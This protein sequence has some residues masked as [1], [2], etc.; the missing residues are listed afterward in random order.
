MSFLIES[1]DKYDVR[2]S[3]VGFADS[4]LNRFFSCQACC[5]R[6][7]SSAIATTTYIREAPQ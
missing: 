2:L 1:K 4:G 5:I 3:V 6:F 7:K